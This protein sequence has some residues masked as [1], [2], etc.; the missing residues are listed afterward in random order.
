MG[1]ANTNLEGCMLGREQQMH[2]EG[3]GGICSLGLEEDLGDGL[4][5]DRGICCICKQFEVQRLDLR[6]RI[7]QWASSEN[8]DA[9]ANVAQAPSDRPTGR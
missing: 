8:L 2:H 3:R 1:N 9:D 7:D 6:Y 5:S 4:S